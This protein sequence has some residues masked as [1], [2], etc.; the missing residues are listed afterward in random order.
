L[1][2][3]EGNKNK[4]ICDKFRNKNF[5]SNEVLSISNK[6][7]IDPK[8]IKHITKLS[9]LFALECSFFDTIINDAKINTKDMMLI[10]IYA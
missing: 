7:N 8:K 6:V 4:P 1:Y 5:P 10:D 9:A 3:A 2:D